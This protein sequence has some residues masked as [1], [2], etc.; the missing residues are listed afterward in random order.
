VT[1][2][3]GD[4][5]TKLTCPICGKRIGSSSRFGAVTSLLFGDSECT[6][7]RLDDA[8]KGAPASSRSQASD[9]SDRCPKCGL[10][11]AGG[12][13]NSSLTGSLLQSS[14]CQCPPDP[15]FADGAMS[16]KFWKLKQDGGGSIFTIPANEGRGAVTANSIDLAP[17]AI[18]GGV[19][20]I[21]ELIGRGGMG[22]VYLAIHETL[23]KK[24]ALKVIPPDEVTEIGWQR[25]QL[26]AR[27][28]AKLNHINLIR[29]TDLGIHEGCLPFYAMDYVEGQNLAEWLAEKGPMSLRRVLRVFGQVCDG[30]ECA[31]RSGILHR[32]L[33]PA[34][35]MWVTSNAGMREAK[36]LDF[37]LAKLTRHDRAKQSLTA[38]GDVFGSPF[39]MSPEQCNGDTLDNRSD[40]YSLGCTMFECL[41]GRPPFIGHLAAVIVACHLEAPA[42]TLASVVGPGIFPDSIE[43]VMA[44]LL[45]KNPDGRYQTLSELKSDLLLVANSE[46]IPPGYFSGDNQSGVGTNQELATET[47]PTRQKTV[48][49]LALSSLVLVILVL[50]VSISG[51]IYSM[52]KNSK[53][54][55]RLAAVPGQDAT[56]EPNVGEGWGISTRT[57][58][59]QKAPG[60]TLVS[61]HI[62]SCQS[63]KGPDDIEY[64]VFKFPKDLALGTFIDRRLPGGQMVATGEVR[65]PASWLPVFRP[66]A[67]FLQDRDN[68]DVFHPDHL[69]GLDL[70]H[71]QPEQK[72]SRL[73]HHVGLLTG[74][75]LLDLDDSDI[76]DADLEDIKKL[77]LLEGLSLNRTNITGA[78]LSRL[79]RLRQLR[80]ISFSE[81]RG[82]SDLL[83]ALRGCDKLQELDL[84]GDQLTATDFKTIATLSNLTLLHVN[85][86]G[87]TSADLVTLSSL[88]KLKGL[89]ASDYKFTAEAIKSLKIMRKHGL[90]QLTIAGPGLSLD[91]MHKVTGI[92]PLARFKTADPGVSSEFM[93]LAK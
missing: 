21:V 26:E 10:K 74:L 32:D 34:N 40:I 17:G 52:S 77:P 12:S 22:E 76:G 73:M 86:C 92:I 84:H 38:V 30:V 45:C 29:V 62:P 63:E 16:A 66:S 64:L 79:P 19:Y 60:R 67:A 78:A 3:A 53:V 13:R 72:D 81:C 89:G 44:K 2:Q 27:A 46:A 71:G 5:G 7:S 4:K 51:S 25:F 58:G 42:P 68:L 15:A 49:F 93:G 39:Y 88:S 75:R 20:R 65:W 56:G 50:L 9:D 47:E 35:I 61:S 80:W 43:A 33:K 85:D 36:V 82:A 37:G 91:D 69:G 55:H 41:T 87:L 18:I 1:E 24:C 11:I 28:V 57:S 54:A 8:A 6:C 31:H 90:E 83:V 59:S 70:S 14:Q 48:L 23:G